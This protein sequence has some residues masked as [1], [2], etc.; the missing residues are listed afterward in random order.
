MR[1][2]EDILLSHCFEWVWNH[3]PQTRRLIYHV[4]NESAKHL[5]AMGVVAGVAD[6]AFH[7]KS[8]TY[9]LEGKTDSGTQSK[10]QKEFEKAVKEHGFSYQIFR[11][12]EEFQT[13]INKILTDGD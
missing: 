10:P 5:K 6:F 1:K 3:R 12:L 13:I 9:F 4:P 11:S 8:K 7:W 2:E